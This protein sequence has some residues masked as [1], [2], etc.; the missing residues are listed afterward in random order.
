M[1]GKSFKL[2]SPFSGVLLDS[3]GAPASGVDVRGRVAD[4]SSR[5][6]PSTGRWA[7]VSDNHTRTRN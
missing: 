5:S 3:N 1:F 4:A 6:L 7:E 2:L